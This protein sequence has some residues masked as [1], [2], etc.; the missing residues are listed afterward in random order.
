MKFALANQ[1]FQMAHRANVDYAHVLHAI[2]HNYPR[3][4]DLPS[5]GF[6][7]GPCLFKDTMQLAAFSHD[8]FP[9]GHAA[10]LINEGLPSYIVETLDNR[11]GLAG[12]TLGILGMAFKGESDDPRSS[13]S[14]KLRKLAQFKGAQVICTDPYVPDPSLLPL[15]DVV[16]RSDVLVIGAPHD[17]YRALDLS[18]REVVD[19]WGVC[20]QGFQL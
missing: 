13:L 19:V 2:K 7:A 10:M 5:P 4:S 6:A 20:G 14:Y 15:D 9:M 8:H 18:G 16:E 1:F 17:Q 11:R 12:R 3:A